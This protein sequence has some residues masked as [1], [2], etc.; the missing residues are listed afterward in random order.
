MNQWVVRF[1]DVSIG[2]TGQEREIGVFHESPDCAS[3]G[4]VHWLPRLLPGLRK[5]CAQI[6]LLEYGWNTD[7]FLRGTIDRV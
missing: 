3:N 7:L 5:D 4:E 2:E 1:E 6:P